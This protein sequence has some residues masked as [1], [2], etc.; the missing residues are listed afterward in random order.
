MGPTVFPRLSTWAGLAG[1]VAGLLAGA[2]CDGAQR[3]GVDPHLAQSLSA[4]RTF[5]GFPLYWAGHKLGKLP[6]TGVARASEHFG[7]DFTF[8]YGTC[9]GSGDEGSC[10]PPMEIQITNLCNRL[11]KDLGIHHLTGRLRGALTS[12][13]EAG[14]DNGGALSLYVQGATITIYGW[15]RK[16]DLEAVSALRGANALAHAQPGQP[17]PAASRKQI[18]GAGC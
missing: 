16:L 17:L 6:L 4:A 12:A 7:E 9:V 5:S 2:G 8:L 13:A 14:A 18:A 3:S 11:P 15:N 10:A 1:A